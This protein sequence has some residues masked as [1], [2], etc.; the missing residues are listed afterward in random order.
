MI[1]KIQAQQTQQKP[2]K[3]EVL[4]AIGEIFSTQP[5]STTPQFLDRLRTNYGWDFTEE[6]LEEFL[7]EGDSDA[8]SDAD[9]ST[10]SSSLQNRK[11]KESS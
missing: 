8:D 1:D 10:V 7:S 5:P 6:G 2:S 9:S 11:D 3:N 4:A